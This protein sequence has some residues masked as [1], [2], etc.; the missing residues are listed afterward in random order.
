MCVFLLLLLLCCPC[1]E[2][3]RGVPSVCFRVAMRHAPPIDGGGWCRAQVVAATSRPQQRGRPLSG[4]SCR[5]RSIQGVFCGPGRVPDGQVVIPREPLMFVASR[6]NLFP[7]QGPDRCW[8]ASHANGQ[9]PYQLFEGR[10]SRTCGEH[11][12]DAR[13]LM[14]SPEAGNVQQKG[15]LKVQRW[16][17]RCL[18]CFVLTVFRVQ[19]FWVWSFRI[20]PEM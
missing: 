17:F 2:W 20:R 6:S 14:S 1:E 18:G 7:G 19:V 11:D 12:V 16:V 9:G 4:T 5:D 8:T 13:P 15:R 3:P 10:N